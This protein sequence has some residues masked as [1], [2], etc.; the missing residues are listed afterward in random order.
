MTTWLLAVESGPRGSTCR[1]GASV[2]LAWKP[3]APDPGGG[4]GASPQ[5]SPGL[6]L[7]AEASQAAPQAAGPASVPAGAAAARWVRTTCGGRQTGSRGQRGGDRR[8]VPLPGWCQD[9][10]P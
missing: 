9:P 6:R 3:R 1:V 8:Q 2:H 7:H 10:I 5:Q 4:D